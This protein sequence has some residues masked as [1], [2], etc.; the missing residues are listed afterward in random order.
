MSEDQP[1]L[2]DPAL[3]REQLQV[4]AAAAGGCA[5]PVR[6]RG[7]RMVVDPVTGE[8][9]SAVRSDEQPGGFIEVACGNRRA[10]VCPSCAWLYKGDT[11]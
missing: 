8:V 6:L 3:S 4:I 10:A 5:R 1:P 2:P 11:C 9:V 7:W